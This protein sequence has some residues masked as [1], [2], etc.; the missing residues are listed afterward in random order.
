MHQVKEVQSLIQSQ[1]PKYAIRF[2]KIAA[3]WQRK[4][5]VIEKDGELSEYVEY[6]D[7]IKRHVARIRGCVES[8]GGAVPKLIDEY[9][10]SDTASIELKNIIDK[11]D[12]IDMR[13]NIYT[14]FIKLA[15]RTNE[16]KEI[17]FTIK[18]KSEPEIAAESAT[19][20]A[21]KPKSVV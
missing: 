13:T 4:L 8:V 6:S 18:K 17:T 15:S 2:N 14:L 7:K 20:S 16:I 10:K 1:K 11:K 12:F 5:A 21:T 9:E 3:R 19:K